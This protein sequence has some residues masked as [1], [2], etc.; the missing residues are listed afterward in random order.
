MRQG[1]LG[2]IYDGGKQIGGFLYWQIEAKPPLPSASSAV[3]TDKNLN[4][5]AN[6]EQF[7]L[8]GKMIERPLI[9]FFSDFEHRKI[10]YEAK[11]K[12]EGIQ[13]NDYLNTLIAREIK[14][15]GDKISLKK[16]K[17]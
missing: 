5:K 6:A 1:T 9:K 13:E 17:I 2:G 3:F 12:I 15:K 16:E 10:Y 14:I 8:L 7:W 4:W 11:G